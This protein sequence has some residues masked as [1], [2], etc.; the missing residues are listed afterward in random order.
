MTF[1]EL[2]DRLKQLDEVLL[3]EVLEINSGQIVDRF[4][5]VVEDKRD[6]IEE[7]LELDDVFSDD[8]EY[9]LGTDDEF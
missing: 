1:V 8:D 4:Q 6:Y 5:D 9:E 7:D 3:L 2:C